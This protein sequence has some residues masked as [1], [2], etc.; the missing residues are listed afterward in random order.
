MKGFRSLIVWQKSHQLAPDIYHLTKKSPSSEQYS[1]TSQLKGIVVSTL[2]NIAEGGRRSQEENTQFLSISMGS[3]YETEYL[4]LFSKDYGLISNKIY[5]KL[6]N[7]IEEIK[8]MLYVLI[9]KKLNT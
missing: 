8:S 5:E 2:T 9:N 3:A 7:S 1:L 6:Q 4:L